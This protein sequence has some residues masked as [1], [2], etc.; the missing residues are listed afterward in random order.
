[1]Q[2]I[3]KKREVDMVSR[4]KVTLV[5]ILDD[6]PFFTELSIGE[7]EKLVRDLLHTYPHLNQPLYGDVEVGYEAS[8]LM[9]QAH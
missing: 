2:S 6:S 4:K 7:R 1:M 9:K 3:F 8:W 5:A